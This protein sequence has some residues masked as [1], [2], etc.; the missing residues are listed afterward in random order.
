ML[1]R[2]ARYL[3]FF[4]HDTSYLLGRT[5]AQ[6]VEEVE[7]ED[8]TLLT[9]D[10]QLAH[11]VPGAL[12]I[13]SHAIGEQLREVRDAFPGA[14]YA[15]TFDRCAECNAPLV[16]WVR[17]PEE[18][19]PSELPRE[20]VEAGLSVYRCPACGRR[21]WDGSHTDRIREKVAEWLGGAGA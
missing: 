11:R 21:Y 13:R 7:R 17:R 4:G 9:R 6:I 19:W 1:G 20:R 10:R 8:R 18:E 3:R 14:P 16:P 15:L 5:D 2:L 12:L